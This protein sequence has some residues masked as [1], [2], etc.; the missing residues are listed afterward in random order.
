MKRLLP[1]S[2]LTLTLVSCGSAVKSEIFNSAGRKVG[3]VVLDG[4]HEAH[5][6]SAQ[7]EDRGKVRG[8][9][10]RDAGGK[11]LGTISQRD[12][13]TFITG[14]DGNDIGTLEEGNTCYGKS[15]EKLGTITA[16][17]DPLIA[18]AGCLAFF[19]R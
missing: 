2:I 14:P 3:T 10:V 18:A 8:N 4:A 1:L 7:E 5:F 13:K 15:T 6:V 16:V 11:K 12:G 19:I 17:E 9:V